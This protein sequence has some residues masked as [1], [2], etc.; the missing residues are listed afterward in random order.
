MVTPRKES[1]WLIFCN[2]IT[3][4]DQR[5][6]ICAINRVLEIIS[7]YV[8]C[9]L[10]SSVPQLLRPVSLDSRAMCRRMG[11]TPRVCSQGVLTTVASHWPQ[12]QPNAATVDFLLNEAG[13][14]SMLRLPED[15]V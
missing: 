6:F 7:Q 1:K 10:M 4:I 5:Y 12:G 9:A 2:K 13:A 15:Q 8:T 14:R 11:S 3:K